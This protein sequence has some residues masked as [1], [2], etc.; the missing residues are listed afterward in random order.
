MDTDMENRDKLIME[1]MRLVGYVLSKYYPRIYRGSDKYEDYRQEG[2]C[3]LISAA[4]HYDSTKGT[5]FSTYAVRFIHGYIQMYKRDYE[6]CYIK[7]PRKLKD[8]F[9]QYIDL[10]AHDCTDKE[11]QDKLHIN[12]SEL[13]ILKALNCLESYESILS[14]RGLSDSEDKVQLLKKEEEGY[15]EFEDQQ[16]VIAM[17]VRVT[18]NLFHDYQRDVW[19][20]YIMGIILDSEVTYKELAEKYQCSQSMINYI[21][22]KGKKALQCNKEIWKNL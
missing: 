7:P 14:K 19:F 13:D 2:L 15:N 22:L 21:I 12:D 1:N 3:G 9:P 17:V 16:S 20:D 18:G 6:L 11:I 8:K 5:K 10:F 4:T